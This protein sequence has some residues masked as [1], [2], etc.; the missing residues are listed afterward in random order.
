MAGV[1]W[2]DDVDVGADLGEF[3]SDKEDG[4]IREE[5]VEDLICRNVSMIEVVVCWRA[6]VIVFMIVVVT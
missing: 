1:D 4:A 2:C 5:V 6:E 3:G